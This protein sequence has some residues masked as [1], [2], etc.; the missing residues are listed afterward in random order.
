MVAPGN[1]QVAG[2]A[3]RVTLLSDETKVAA[4]RVYFGQLLGC[5][6]TSPSRSPP[7]G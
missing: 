2:R 3:R 4:D 7:T 1:N 5:T 6:T